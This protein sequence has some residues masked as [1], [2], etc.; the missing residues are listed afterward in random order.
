MTYSVSDA[1][2][3]KIAED[4]GLEISFD[5]Q[6]PGVHNLTTGEV[7]NL[8]DYF[9]E[10]YEYEAYEGESTIKQL[11]DIHAHKVQPKKIKNSYDEFSYFSGESNGGQKIA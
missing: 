7:S 5:S 10:F 9:D 3:K 6:E 1:E 8:S 11:D 4:L 2:M